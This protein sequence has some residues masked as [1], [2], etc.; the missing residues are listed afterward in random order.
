MLAADRVFPAAIAQPGRSPALTQSLR[1]ILTAAL[2]AVAAWALLT[3]VLLALP[4]SVAL[5]CMFA[6]L[7]LFL[8]GAHLEFRWPVAAGG[9][10]MLA[11][12]FAAALLG[13][14]G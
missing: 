9:V 2:L 12:V 4:G 7:V 3:A 10:M 5:G 6:G 13:V 14:L 8:V 1:R 11:G